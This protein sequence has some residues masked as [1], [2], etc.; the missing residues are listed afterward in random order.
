MNTPELDLVAL[1]KV[2]ADLA[3]SNVALR[4][5]IEELKAEIEELKGPTHMRTNALKEFREFTHGKPEVLCATVSYQ[6]INDERAII[7]DLPVS[8]ALD[9]TNRFYDIL[10]SI[11]YDN[12]F[13]RQELL[14]TIWFCDESWAERAEYD[15]SEWWEYHS[16]PEIPE[17]LQ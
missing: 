16:S 11:T 17:K 12:G 6:S 5:N 2:N 1:C 7:A 15:G 10:S 4:A 14:G 13:G 3:T 9:I 8:A